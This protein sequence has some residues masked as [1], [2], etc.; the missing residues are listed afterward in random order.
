MIQLLR[1]AALLLVLLICSCKK[2]EEPAPSPPAP[3]PVNPY[4]LPDCIDIPPGP[5]PFGWTDSTAN[6]NENVN[7]FMDLPLRPSSYVYCVNGKIFPL[8]R[9]YSLEH[10]SSARTYLGNRGEHLPHANAAGWLVFGGAD[11]NIYKVKINGDSLTQLSTQGLFSDPKWEPGGTN[12]YCFQQG[13]SQTPSYLVK[14][15]ANGQGLGS[16]MASYPNSLI[17]KT[18]EHFYLL[19]ADNSNLA[20]YLVN[21]AL[22]TETLVLRSGFTLGANQNDFLNLCIDP[23]EE[24]LYWSNARGILHH[25]IPTGKTDTLFRNCESIT[26]L[27]PCLSQ[28]GESLLFCCKILKPLNSTVLYRSYRSFEYQL[29]RKEWRELKFFPN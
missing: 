11:L 5:S 26:F 17:S 19:R 29:S 7:F 20:L 13:S 16:F 23:K 28:D 15:G 8:N 6:D 24:N 14:I 9:L 4:P 10:G 3:V 12:L 22:N 18:P 27:N 2:K 1:I 25:N 21:K